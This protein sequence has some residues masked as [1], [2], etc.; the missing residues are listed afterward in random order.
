MIFKHI[1]NST[2]EKS[3]YTI[4][5]KNI[6]VSQGH[7]GSEKSIIAGLSELETVYYDKS[8]FEKNILGLALD[9]L[10]YNERVRETTFYRIP[11]ENKI[12]MFVISEI[13]KF[14]DAPLF[15]REMSF[16]LKKEKFAFSIVEV[17]EKEWKEGTATPEKWQIDKELTRKFNKLS[18]CAF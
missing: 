17:Q 5:I 11:E 14:K 6:D 8:N 2:T 10:K 12:V 16:S 4:S 3:N 18:C 9:V 1:E 7:W 13:K 15:E